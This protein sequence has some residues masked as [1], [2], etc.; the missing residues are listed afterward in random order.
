MV[1]KVK[2]LLVLEISSFTTKKNAHGNLPW[3]RTFN[4]IWR[5]QHRSQIKYHL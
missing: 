2:T 3:P 4:R 5:S 1:Q